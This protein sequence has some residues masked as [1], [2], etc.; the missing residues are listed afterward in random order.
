MAAKKDN[1]RAGLAVDYASAPAFDPSENVKA[2]NEAANK[3]QDDLREFQG[4]LFEAK[5][6]CQEE[7]TSLHMQHI[8]ETRNAEA[9]RVDEQAALRADFA[10]KLRDAEAKRIDA[11]RVVDVN[12]V[13]VA[14]QR[15]S[16]QATV[17][18][19]TVQQSAETLRSL[20]ATTANT[21]AVAQRQVDDTLS[22]RITTL[23]QAQYKGEGK[24]SVS[25]PAMAAILE[26]LTAGV[27]ALQGSRSEG[28]DKT[29]GIVAIVLG[30]VIAAVAA[31]GGV[32]VSRAPSASPQII[33]VPS[34]PPVVGA[35]QTIQPHTP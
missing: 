17:L 26:K 19:T 1:G 16:D 24:T 25:D 4:R 3:R 10:E 32:Y 13:A 20:V 22:G 33:Y 18:A 8:T 30:I 7:I 2:L 28:V 14:A 23:E 29:W 12:A 15:S 6:H 21:Q 11:I 31:F 27:S 35:P 34:P 9:R 5:L